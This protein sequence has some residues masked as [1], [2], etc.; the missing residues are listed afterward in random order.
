MLSKT[1]STLI[2]CSAAILFCSR[3]FHPFNVG[4]HGHFMI[5]D[6]F[7]IVSTEHTSSCFLHT[8]RSSPRFI[9]VFWWILL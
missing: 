2:V 5:H 6:W 3:L 1:D 9:D 8:K 7:R 4:F